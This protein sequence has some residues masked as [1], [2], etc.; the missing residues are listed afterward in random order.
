M[1]PDFHIVHALLENP[2]REGSDFTPISFESDKVGAINTRL[3]IAE[4]QAALEEVCKY[5]GHSMAF[6]DKVLTRGYLK[7]TLLTEDPE[8]LNY[9]LS[10]LVE[11]GIINYN[12]AT[13]DGILFGSES[14]QDWQDFGGRI[15]PGTETR[16]WSL[17][18]HN[19]GMMG[20]RSYTF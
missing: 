5:L 1:N 14:W 10:M 18:Y 2:C 3:K 15:Y 11:R 19:K 9:A 16:S 13:I 8:Q 6:E 17:S 4:I 7:L 12:P 20:W